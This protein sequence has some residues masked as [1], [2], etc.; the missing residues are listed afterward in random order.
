MRGLANVREAFAQ[1]HE[2]L[3]AFVKTLTDDLSSCSRTATA[4]ETGEEG[5]DR[6][7]AAYGD[8]YN[9]PAALK[10]KYD[11]TNFFRLNQNIKPAM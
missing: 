7:K 10:K 5:A 8:T 4:Q 6:V 9:R 2:G 1:S 3:G 11:P